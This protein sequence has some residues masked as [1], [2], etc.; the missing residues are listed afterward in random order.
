MN[1]IMKIQ[2]KADHPSLNENVYKGND[3]QQHA[4][5]LS[6]LHKIV[7]DPDSNIMEQVEIYIINYVTLNMKSSRGSISP[8]KI[9]TGES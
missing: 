5:L 4:A 3:Y 1:F 8:G 9:K 7:H 2:P 6:L